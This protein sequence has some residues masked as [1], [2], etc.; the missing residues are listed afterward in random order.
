[1]LAAA[2]G[3]VSSWQLQPPDSVVRKHS[4]AAGSSVHISSPG[5]ARSVAVAR[6]PEH[7]HQPYTRDDDAFLWANRERPDEEVASELGR[8]AKSCSARLEKLRRPTT[9]GHRRLFGEDDNE[10]EG[11][12][13]AL[14]PA[15][16]CIQ[17]IIHD[18]GLTAAD[19]VVGYRDR[20]QPGLLRAPFE[21]PN[22]S[23]NGAARM[24]V[25]ALPE[26][27][28]EALWYREIYR[29]YTG[30]IPEIYGRYKEP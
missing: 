19:F 26:H 6:M 25:L 22:Q 11:K 27:R 4:V 13:A 1:M 7:V 24:L 12:A 17:R 8:G 30:D 21:A 20:F 23:V 29:R 18:P 15:H 16:E 9:A 2:A 10:E 28:I 3:W 5:A 14:R